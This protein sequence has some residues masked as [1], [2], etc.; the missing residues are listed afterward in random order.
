MATSLGELRPWGTA[1]W[2]IESGQVRGGGIITELDDESPNLKV[3]TVGVSAY[4][5]GMAWTD[6][7][8]DYVSADVLDVYRELWGVL[9]SKP[10]GNLNVTFS[11]MK[12]GVTIG[13][14][15]R[16]EKKRRL[17]KGGT[18]TE[19]YKVNTSSSNAEAERQRLVAVARSWIGVPYVWGGESRRGVDCSGLTKLVFGQLGY[20][21]PHY[22]GSQAQMG[23]AVSKPLPGDLVCWPGHVAIYTG[24]GRI[25]HAP[26]PGS[27]VRTGSVWYPCRFRRILTGKGTTTK[28]VTKKRTVNTPDRWV[29]DVTNIPAEPYTIAPWEVDDIGRV[30]DEMISQAGV[31]WVERSY[32]G[33][34]G[35]V[36][37]RIDFGRPIGAKK[38][39]VRLEIGVNVAEMPDISYHSADYASEIVGWG[40]GEGDA[41]LRTAPIRTGAKGLRRVRKVSLLRNNSVDSLT[42]ATRQIAQQVSQQMRVRRFLVNQSDWC[43]IG[44]L[45]VGDWVPIVGVTDWQKVAQWVRIMQIEEDGDTGSAVITTE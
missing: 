5:K 41:K 38:L 15:G 6:S 37:H 22:S 30:L 26:Y 1:A 42:N 23:K 44:S 35:T 10:D 16:V 13:K 34:N 27:T 3:E 17:I 19:T 39:N 45:N 32:K 2:L 4:P 8:R 7:K 31:D 24:G 36:E 29:T 21:L 11:P 28:T 33:K 43:P 40:P 20:S 9:Q 12:A 25:I 14:P 18:R